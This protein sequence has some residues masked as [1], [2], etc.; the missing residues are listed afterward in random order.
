M[1]VILIEDVPKLGGIGDHVTVKAGYARN[2]LIPQKLAITANT[3]NKRRLEHQKRLAAARLAKARANAEG[4]A[5]KLEG[6]TLSVAR[7]VGDQD[8]LYGSVTSLDLER[9]MQE[10]GL[11]LDRR[12][13]EL[14]EPIKALGSYEVPVR[15]RDDLTATLKVEVVAEA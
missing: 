5:K 12:K 8:K 15:L 2:Y 9:A 10:Q 1:D 14:E 11:E 7:K 6:L 3:S 4:L 13:I